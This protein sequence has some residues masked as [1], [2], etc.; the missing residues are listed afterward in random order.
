MEVKETK[1]VS[2]DEVIKI[3]ED[4]KSEPTYEQKLALEHAKKSS[5][6]KGKSDKIRKEL[7]A[8]GIASERSIIKILEIMPKN[9]MTLMQILAQDRKTYSDEDVNKLLAIT[10]G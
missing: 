2:V 10:K 6:Q 1:I 5:P 3:L 7:E 8:S 4:D 9:R